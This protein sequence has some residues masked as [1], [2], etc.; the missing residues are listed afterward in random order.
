MK[1]IVWIVAAFAAGMFVSATSTRAKAETQAMPYW[2]VPG[3]CM[4]AASSGGTEV[5][6]ET[7]GAWAKTVR[8]GVRPADSPE[9]WR[10]LGVTQWLERRSEEA[11]RRPGQ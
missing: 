5:V 7:Q 2:V 9:L 6:L 10:N 1:R 3:A 4:L 11:C 8:S